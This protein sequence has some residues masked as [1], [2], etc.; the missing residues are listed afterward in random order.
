M[1]LLTEKLIAV[2][3]A[4][5][6]DF[7]PCNIAFLS[8]P[9]D[10]ERDTPEVLKASAVAFQAKPAGWNFLTC[11]PAEM[12]DVVRRYAVIAVR[13]QTVSSTTI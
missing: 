7:R 13:T 4:V 2:K 3:N 10:P 9:L 11:P 5:R 6:E 12:R 8:I 1:T